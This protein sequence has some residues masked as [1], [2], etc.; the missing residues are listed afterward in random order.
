[1]RPHKA[2]EPWCILLMCLTAG[3]PP[4]NDAEIQQLIR[5]GFVRIAGAFPCALA[6]QCRSI[7]LRDTGCDE[8][9]PRTW[10]KLVIRL[11]MYA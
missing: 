2:T 9:D 8:G 5:D 11:G 10:T 1:M 7:L 4:L 3:S 6:E